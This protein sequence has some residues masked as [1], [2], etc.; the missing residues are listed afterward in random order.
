VVRAEVNPG[1]STT[2]PL[3]EG[4]AGTEQTIAAIRRQVD[5]ALRDPLVRQTAG[6][7]VS[8]VRPYDDLGEARAVY[9]WVL[10]HIRFV[11][12][13]VGKETISSARWIL[14]HGFGDCDDING[15]LLPALLG[16]IGYRTR[17]VTISNNP[18]APEQFSHVY[19]EVFVRG[20]WVPV[21]AARPG[22]RFGA[23]PSRFFRKRVWS[24]SDDRFEDIRGLNGY[25]AMGGW[26][27]DLA[28]VFQS[29]TPFATSVI[30]TL[31]AP[32]STLV[33]YT[34]APAASTFRPTTGG[35]GAG[36]NTTTLLIGGAL[37]GGA[38]FLAKQGRA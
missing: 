35:F 37:V 14:T 15:I 3:L 24:L 5:E 34:P 20:L 28:K 16:A 36:I 33:P 7:I 17:L 30:T 6:F 2:V 4:D 22:A 32:K 27:E 1:W 11:K 8:R 31:R 19:A 29:A 9:Q 18:M 12:D 26:A 13:P 10:G 25:H 21:D 38:Y 23:A